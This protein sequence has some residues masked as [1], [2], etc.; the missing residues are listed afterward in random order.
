MN[1]IRQKAS[2]EGLNI[3]VLA[4]EG[5]TVSDTYS[6]RNYGMMGHDRDG[7]SF[8]LVGKDGRVRWRADYGG[9]P[10]Y[11]MFVPDDVLLGQLKKSL[12]A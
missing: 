12:G 11:T 2:D 5:G 10:K 9:A 4:D 6:A 8:V 1:L 7:H 3:P